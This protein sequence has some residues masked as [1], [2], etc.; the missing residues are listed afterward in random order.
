MSRN[1]VPTEKY[2]VKRSVHV[3]LQ[4]L[5]MGLILLASGCK[6]PPRPMQ[7]SNMMAR[8]NLRLSDA[9][10]KF[11][12]ALAPKGKAPDAGSAQGPYNEMKAALSEA[13]AEFDTISPPLNSEYGWELLDKYRT[14]LQSQQTILDTCYTPIMNTL[15][16]NTIAPGRKSVIINALL[17][18]AGE[19]ERGP[20]SHLRAVHKCVLRNPQVRGEGSLNRG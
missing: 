18:K 11:A 16:D 12:K 1:K 19:E 8:A 3:L 15:K 10:N 13:K 5:L 14:F 4:A 2:I 9:A 6:F 17:V 20:L 7:F